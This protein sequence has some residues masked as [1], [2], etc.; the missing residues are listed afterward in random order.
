M[1]MDLTCVIFMDTYKAFD[2]VEHK[3]MLKKI[4]NYG[5]QGVALNLIA[6]YLHSRLQYT[7]SSQVFVNSGWVTLL[8]LKYIIHMY[9]VAYWDL[10]FS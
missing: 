4:N 7:L 8:F 9:K 2:H 6:S 1:F 5:V 3:A 10:F